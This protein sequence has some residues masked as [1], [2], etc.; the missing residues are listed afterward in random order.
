MKA[1]HFFTEEENNR[2]SAAIREVE[3]KTAGEIAVMVVDRSD[4]YPEGTILAGVILGGLVALLAT[5][6]FFTSS[7]HL[8]LIVFFGLG[9][10]TGWLASFVPGL[11]RMFIPKTRLEEQVR[12]QAVQSFFEKGLYKTRDGTGVLFFISL[13][14]RKVWL[15]ADK[16]IYEKISPTELQA[17]ARDMAKSVKEGRAA[18]ILCRQIGGIGELL[19]LH[20]PVKADDINEL[21]D[22]VIIG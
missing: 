18:D 4:L 2:I 17:Y 22:H 3:T 20:F 11:K 19:A 9:L 15:L 7:L 14:E 6:L 10:L 16:G 8:F 21:P 12:E 5:D 13:F 1:E